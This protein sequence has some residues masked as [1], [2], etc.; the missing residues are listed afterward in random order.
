MAR[1][2][3][4]TELEAQLDDANDY[5]D[6]LESKLNDI[7]G[8]A[9]D[10]DDDVDDDSE[11]DDDEDDESSSLWYRAF[12]LRSLLCGVLGADRLRPLLRLPPLLLP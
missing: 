8:I 5:I 3:T 12:C 9:A 11:D 2:K 1:G 6:G 7:V 4:I 10:E